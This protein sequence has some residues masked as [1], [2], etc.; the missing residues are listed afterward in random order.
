[1]TW[2]VKSD[3]VGNGE[4]TTAC[5]KWFVRIIGMPAPLA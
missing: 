3:D 1:M 4:A 5:M 2:Q